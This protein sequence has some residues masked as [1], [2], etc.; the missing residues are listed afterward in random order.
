M[1]SINVIG[2]DHS[3]PP[4]LPLNLFY[5]GCSPDKLLITGKEQ[6]QFYKRYLNWPKS[7]LKIIPSFRFK[8]EKK[9]F[10]Q[11]RIF[12]PFELDDKITFLKNLEILVKLNMIRNIKDYLYKEG[13]LYSGLS[14]SG[15]AVFG[16]F[17]NHKKTKPIMKKL[18]KHISLFKTKKMK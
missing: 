3:A 5:D 17:D 4:A 14:G 15:S 12:L 10:F 8:N 9:S 1:R 13:A 6:S 7:K 18:N 16:I 11:N 2:Y